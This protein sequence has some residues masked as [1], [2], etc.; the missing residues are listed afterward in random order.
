[1]VFTY[2]LTNISKRFHQETM[3]E[4]KK[5]VDVLVSAETRKY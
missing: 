4:K 1:M 3:T 2:Y 5:Y